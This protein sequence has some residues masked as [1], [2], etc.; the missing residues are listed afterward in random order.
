MPPYIRITIQAG[1]SDHPRPSLLG[2]D[3]SSVK[4]SGRGQKEVLALAAVVVGVSVVEA[5]GLGEAP[6]V[7]AD[8]VVLARVV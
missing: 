3:H 7:V 1:H 6:D 8:A 5:A 4:Q 2:T